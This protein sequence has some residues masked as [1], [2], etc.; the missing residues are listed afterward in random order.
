MALIDFPQELR[1]HGESFLLKEAPISV[2]LFIRKWLLVHPG[3]W[4]GGEWNGVG[5]PERSL[6]QEVD[7]FLKRRKRSEGK[8][9]RDLVLQRGGQWAKA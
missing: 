4:E 3:R 8:V 7:G 2:K 1:I 6:L 5:I 9:I